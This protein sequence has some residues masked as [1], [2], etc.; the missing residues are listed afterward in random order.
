MMQFSIDKYAKV[1]FKESSILESKNITLDINR[2]QPQRI[3]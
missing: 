1:I 2:K 3:Q